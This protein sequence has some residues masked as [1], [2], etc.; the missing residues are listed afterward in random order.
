MDALD[1]GRSLR[2]ERVDQVVRLQAIL[3]LEQQR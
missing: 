2:R 1:L 3:A